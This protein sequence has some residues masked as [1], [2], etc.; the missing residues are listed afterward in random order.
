[1]G[2]VTGVDEPPPV[3][4]RLECGDP[5]Q[6]RLDV[7]RVTDESVHDAAD[8]RAVPD[9][10]HGPR[11]ARD[12]SASGL[13]DPVHRCRV[14]L[15]KRRLDEWVVIER[16]TIETGRERC[17]RPNI[18]VVVEPDSVAVFTESGL[19]TKLG[20]ELVCDLRGR[21]DGPQER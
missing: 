12:D 19:E 11:F 2:D 18:R 1:M 8:G 21:L 16:N 17:R 13:A 4:H 3:A 9:E 10:Q 15:G 5:T 14:R 20:A 7:V 6:R